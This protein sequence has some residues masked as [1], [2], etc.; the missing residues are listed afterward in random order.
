MS[1]DILTDDTEVTEQD[2]ELVDDSSYEVEIDN[3]ADDVDW[4]AEALKYK[5]IAKRQAKKLTATQ[6]QEA[7][8]PK[9]VIKKEVANPSVPEEHIAQLVETKLMQRDIDS[10]DVSDTIKSEV[11]KY[12]EL[13]GVSVKVA[14]SSDYIQFLKEKEVAKTRAEEASISTQ[15]KSQPRA[16]FTDANPADFDLSTKEGREEWAAYKKYL[17]NS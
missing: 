5:N 13:N 12:A 14:A 8:A 1:D 2:G 15:R 4:K 11:K 16:D 9:V 6:Q 7:P 17:K 10:L 3:E